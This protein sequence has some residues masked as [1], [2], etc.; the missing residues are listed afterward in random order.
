M[1]SS[2][3]ATSLR[4]G[5]SS[6]RRPG[7]ITGG[8]AASQLGANISEQSRVGSVARKHTLYTAEEE[9]FIVENNYGWRIGLMTD[10]HAEKALSSIYAV[11]RSYGLE[12]K[13]VS[14]FQLLIRTTA[15]TWEIL[16]TASQSISAAG[17]ILRTGPGS[18]LSS[19]APIRIGAGAAGSASSEDPEGEDIAGSLQ[20][21]EGS[22]HPR[23]ARPRRPGASP[24]SAAG[25]AGLRGNYF[26]DLQ[27]TKTGSS[28]STAGTSAASPSL[29]PKTDVPVSSPARETSAA[30]PP[31][32]PVILSLYFFRIQEQHDKGYLV[33][34]KVVRN[35]MVAMD[36]ILVLSDALIRKIG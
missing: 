24:Y 21:D 9:K 27:P 17:R 20:R 3:A 4:G 5:S 25:S 1:P 13:M 10:L 34:F 2:L 29:K 6:F 32:N 28:P 35:V 14:P 15:E 19:S 16:T 33:D 18:S 8:S 23:T 22:F 26:G 12:W 30:V 11:L 36:L 7:M 31:K